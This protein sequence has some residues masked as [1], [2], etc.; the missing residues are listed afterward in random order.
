[1][2]KEAQSR[3][4]DLR[5]EVRTAAAN[6]ASVEFKPSADSMVYQFSLRDWSSTGLGILAREDSEVLRHISAGQVISIVLYKGG[7]RKTAER[8]KAEIQHI[9][10]PEHGRHPSHKIVGIRILERE[11]S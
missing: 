2:E 4:K 9:S 8:L 7:R 11:S 1:M 6:G 3:N 10:D 5:A